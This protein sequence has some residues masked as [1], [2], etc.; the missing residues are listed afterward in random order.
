MKRLWLLSL[1]A[2]LVL[3]CSTNYGP[4][5]NPCANGVPKST[6]NRPIIC[7]DDRNLANIKTSP[8][9]TRA[10]KSSPIRWFT[11]SGN[12]GLSIVFDDDT[13]VKRA[14]VNCD[15]GSGCKAILTGESAVG[16]RC[17][18]SVRLTRNNEKGEEDPIIIIDPGMYDEKDIDP[19]SQ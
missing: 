14:E 18:Y 12:G 1:V 15:R 19:F 8:Y 9:E 11:M 10:K 13:C 5:G 16:T 2:V 4:P 6:S 7:V 3:S 17:H